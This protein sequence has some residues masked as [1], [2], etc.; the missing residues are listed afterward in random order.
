MGIEVGANPEAT[1]AYTVTLPMD[2]F[3]PTESLFNY[4]SIVGMLHYMQAHTRPDIPF[5]VS[6][7]SRLMH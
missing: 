4:A 7:L 1:P 2:K 6:Q 5:A 3:N